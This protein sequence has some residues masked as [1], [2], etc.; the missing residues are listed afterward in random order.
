MEFATE[1]VVRAALAGDTL[2]EVPTNLKPDAPSRLPH[3]RTWSDGWHTLRLLLLLSPRWVFFYPGLVL[4]AL[5][6]LARPTY[7]RG[8]SVL[9]QSESIST[10]SSSRAMSHWSDCSV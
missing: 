3:L 9:V 10:R 5:G 8:Q 7:C 6:V 1:M 2:A 4:I